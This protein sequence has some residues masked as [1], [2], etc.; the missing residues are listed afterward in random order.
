VGM[1]GESPPAKKMRSGTLAVSSS[2]G[3]IG[4][5]GGA[6]GAPSEVRSRKRSR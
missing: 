3:R 4:G 2:N 5:G 6:G 1:F